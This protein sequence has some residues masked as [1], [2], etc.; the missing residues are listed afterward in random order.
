MT[1]IA[2]LRARIQMASSD[3]R[4]GFIYSKSPSFGEKGER[5]DALIG[6]RYQIFDK[7]TK[8]KQSNIFSV[9]D[10]KSDEMSVL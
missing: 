8:S 4:R 1:F 6:N 3:S 10:T 9:L 5:D 7:L 2:L